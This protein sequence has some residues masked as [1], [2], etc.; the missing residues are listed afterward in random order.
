LSNV[1]T[2]QAGAR[3]L[4][5]LGVSGP[6]NEFV[7]KNSDANHVRFVQKIH[8]MVVEGAY[9]VVHTDADGNVYAINGELLDPLAVPSA[10]PT[11]DSASA[12]AVALAESRVSS[13]FHDQCSKPR[14]TIV[15]GL[16]DGEAHLAW[17]CIVRFDVTG[18]DGYEKPYRDQIFARALI[19]IHPLIH[20]AL[21]MNIKNCNTR[22]RCTT[23]ATKTS[24]I[25]TG[26]L[27]IDS[28]HNCHRNIQLLL[29]KVWTRLHR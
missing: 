26:D 16:D 27:A 28:A 6:N 22:T 5:T 24:P 25:N 11:I 2:A 1:A 12:I 23:V 14:L 17:T 8:G 3:G 7:P 9:M 21:S 18:E 10:K 20:G 4:E 13:E 19:Q 29:S 15:R